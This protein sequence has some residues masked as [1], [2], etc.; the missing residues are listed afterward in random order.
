MTPTE[1]SS[2]WGDEFVIKPKETNTE[3]IQQV[4]SPKKVDFK[5]ILDSKKLTIP[6]KITYI[7]KQVHQILGNFIDNTM[8]IRTKEELVNYIDVAIKNG[9]IAIDTETNNSLDYLTCKLMGACIYTPSMKQAY[10][11]IN[12]KDFYYNTL[13]PNQLTEQDIKEQFERLKDTKIIMHNGKFDYQV[14]KCTCNVTLDIYW[15]T[16]IASHLI[17]EDGS[18]KLKD[19]YVK[20]VDKSQEKYSITSLFGSVPYEYLPPEVF[21]PYSA[22]DAYETY[23][24]YLWQ[25]DYFNE[26]ENKELLPLLHE[27][28]MPI[29]KVAAEMELTGIKIDFEYAERLKAKYIPLREQKE[30]EIE[31][32]LKQLQPKIDAW[33]NSKDALTFV[34]NKQKKY[35]LSDPINL[36][37]PTQLAILFYDILGVEPFSKEAPRGTGEDQLKEIAEKYG[38]EICKSILELREFNKMLDTYIEKLPKIAGKDGRIHCSFNQL[39]TVTGRFSSSEPNL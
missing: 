20:L 34:G 35:Q 10:I 30:K 37:S 21:A 6:E 7:E 39:G 24:L 29:L 26:D 13:L 1:L 23:K 16:M 14:L 3:I 15:D 22:T 18:H 25:V 32:Q 8:C 33:K 19:L 11:P 28:E 4:K 12:H 31:E 2:L 27:V 38:F 9:V 17:D 5:K 36:A